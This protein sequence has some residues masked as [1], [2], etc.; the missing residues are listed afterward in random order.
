VFY[1]I[2]PFYGKIH[3]FIPKNEPKNGIVF[4]SGKLKLIKKLQL[5]E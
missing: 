3:I 2:Y 5:G 4:L 1:I